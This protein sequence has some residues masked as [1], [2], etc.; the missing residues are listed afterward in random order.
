MS[1]DF[2][3]KD[4]SSIRSVYYLLSD[5]SHVSKETS[6]PQDSR[7]QVLDL[8]ILCIFMLQQD[9]VTTPSSFRIILCNWKG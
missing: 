4:N 8:K 6:I 3:I 5:F 1:F 7:K 9:A 2:R